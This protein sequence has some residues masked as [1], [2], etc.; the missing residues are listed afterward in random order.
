ML[1]PATQILIAATVVATPHIDTA[2]PAEV[3]AT[4]PSTANAGGPPAAIIGVFSA[5]ITAT[6]TAPIAITHAILPVALIFII[7]LLKSPTIVISFYSIC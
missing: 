2:A 4:I 1:P 6:L 3:V 5:A 7:F